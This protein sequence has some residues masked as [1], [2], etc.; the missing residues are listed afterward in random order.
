MKACL[1]LML[2]TS[3]ALG[4]RIVCRNL[5]TGN[6]LV[7]PQT[8]V[9]CTGVRFADQP[10]Q[11][12]FPDD[13]LPEVGD[14]WMEIDGVRAGLRYV[15]LNYIIAVLPD[16]TVRR[17]TA[18][19]IARINIRGRRHTAWLQVAGTAP[20]MFSNFG[21]RPQAVAYT[22]GETVYLPEYGAIPAGARVQLVCTGTQ[23][24]TAVS[25]LLDD[26]EVPAVSEPFPRIGGKNY[27]IFDLPPGLHGYVL[28]QVA[29]DGR[30]SNI[31][32]LL[33]N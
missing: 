30:K 15:T 1:L 17:W 13:T 31:L 19:K 9:K 3:P 26:R 21:E 23:R 18:F 24:A 10:A 8:T 29:A 14:V 27:V 22:T 2:L 5:A 12:P 25:V 16:F 4:E 7:A 33:I 28:I 32:S 20:G 11:V 6:E